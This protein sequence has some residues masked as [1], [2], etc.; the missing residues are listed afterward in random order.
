MSV[1]MYIGYVYS[2]AAFSG[3]GTWQTFA[4]KKCKK[5]IKN[6]KNSKTFGCAVGGSRPCLLCQSVWDILDTLNDAM[7][8]LAWLYFHLYLRMCTYMYSLLYFPVSIC[9]LSAAAFAALACALL[10]Q[11]YPYPVGNFPRLEIFLASN[12]VSHDHILGPKK[13][14]C[15]DVRL[16]LI[17]LS[18]L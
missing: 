16:T 8:V 1:C 10:T 5:K 7:T 15:E 2:V 13:T 12:K 11:A 9:L 3:H 4:N 18:W 17:I 6:A 14:S